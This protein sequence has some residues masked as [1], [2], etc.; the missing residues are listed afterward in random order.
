MV[1]IWPIII[2]VASFIYAGTSGIISHEQE[3]IFYPGLSIRAFLETRRQ[4]SQVL[5]NSH[6]GVNV[7]RYFRLIAL[8]STEMLFSLPFSIYLLVNNLKNP[9]NPWVSWADTHQNF[10]RVVYWPM[11]LIK[12]LPQVERVLDVN[13]W[14]T[15]VG[16]FL[17]FLWFGMGAESVI[18]Y[19]KVLRVLGRPFGIKAKSKTEQLGA[20]W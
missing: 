18:E 17:F 11:I 12:T 7:S 13:L 15:P 1:L 2:G 5:S 19:M 16:G 10:S 6:S 14:V 20:A 9:Q 3:L 4:F 8:S